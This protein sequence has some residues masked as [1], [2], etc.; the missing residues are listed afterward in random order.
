M[1]ATIPASI[2]DSLA[3]DSISG[4]WNGWGTWAAGRVKLMKLASEKNGSRDGRLMVVSRDLQ[5][6]VPVAEIAPTLQS[7]L[8][9]WADTAPELQTVFERLQAGVQRRL[10]NLGSRKGKAYETRI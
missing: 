9:H 4:R 8:E 2:G 5:Q 1:R 6:A 7:A 3:K 10:G